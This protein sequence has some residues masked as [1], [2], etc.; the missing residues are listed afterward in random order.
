MRVI[1][2]AACNDFDDAATDLADEDGSLKSLF[3]EKYFG[4]Y[5]SIFFTLNGAFGRLL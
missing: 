3:S 4:D 5:R 1:Y 2:A